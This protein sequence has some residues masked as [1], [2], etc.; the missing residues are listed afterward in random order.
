LLAVV[1]VANVKDLKNHVASY[2]LSKSNLCLLIIFLALLI[3]LLYSDD[4]RTGMKGILA[5]I[6]LVVLPLSMTP[7]KRLSSQQLCRL[8]VIFVFSCLTISA[9]YFIQTSIRIGLFD[10]SYKLETGPVG[11][12]SHYLVYHLTYHQLTPSIHAVFFSLYLALAVLI[13]I[14]DFEKKTRVLAVV[15]T[16]MIIYFL[17]YLFLLLSATINFALYSFII[18]ALFFKYSFKKP[19]HYLTFFGWIIIGTAITNYLFIVKSIGPD[20][21]DIVYRFDS[22]A[23]NQNIIVS[24][25]AAILLGIALILVK[26][27][28]KIKHTLTL[29]GLF[30]LV[31]IAGFIYLKTTE[32]RIQQGPNNVSIRASYAK[33]AFRIIGE[34]PFFGVGVGDKKFSLIERDMNLGDKRYTEFGLDTRPDDVFNPHNQFFSFWLDAGIL[35]VLCLAFFFIIEFQHAFRHRHILYV[36]LLYCFCFFCLTDVALMVQRGQIFFLFFI[37]LFKYG[38]NAS[39]KNRQFS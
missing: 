27:H 35:P 17:I 13:I 7:L 18:A 3:S 32:P 37:C 22:P 26:V 30:L 12:K 38:I 15:Y 11:Y 20:I 16:L 8:K 14:F 10:G 28:V 36:G 6:P 21:G 34:H 39:P 19:I 25:I 2:L 4:K 24:F 23:I 5:A 31:I 1:F 33:E 29:A 9:F